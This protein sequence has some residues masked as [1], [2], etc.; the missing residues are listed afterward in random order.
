[1]ANPAAEAHARVLAAHPEAVVVERGRYH[2]KHRLA[3]GPDGKPRYVLDCWLPPIAGGAPDTVNKQVAASENDGGIWG[4]AFFATNGT[5]RYVG[6]DINS[7]PYEVF[8]RWE[9][10]TLSGTIDVS[11]IEVYCDQAATGTPLRKIRGVDEDNPPAPTSRAEFD[12]DPLTT[13]GV[14]WDGAWSVNAWNQ[15]GSLNAI[16][17]E[18]VDTYTISDDAVMVQIKD[19]RGGAANHFQRMRMYDYAGNLH[20][21]KLHIEY[22][23]GAAPQTLTPSAVTVPLVIPAPTLALTL[24]LSPTPVAMPLAVPA[25]TLLLTKTITP[26]PV[27]LP[28]AIPAP[29]LAHSLTL[30]P[31]P[32]SITLVIPAPTLVFGRILTPSPVAIALAIPAPTL[33]LTKTLAPDP[34]TIPL[35][36]PAPTLVLSPTLIPDPVTIPLTIPAPTLALSL[37]ITPDALAM[38]LAIPAPTV[39]LTKT[40]TPDPVAIALAIPAPTLIYPLILVPDPVSITLVIPAPTLVIPQILTPDPVTV[41]LVIP[42][43]SVTKVLVLTPDPVPILLVIPIPVIRTAPDIRVTGSVDTTLQIEGSVDTT[44]SVTGRDDTTISVKGSV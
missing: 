21:A 13:A 26:D 5:I 19:D 37:I 3:D 42:A 4:A 11:Y 10:V 15:S 34:V 22:T 30:T 27:S 8:A 38:P 25:P 24:T 12:A 14:D 20:G 33:L 36:I 39:V 9:G 44:I 18:L 40:L 43:P 2:I 23:G 17:Q 6:I 29:T 35:A 7:L 41:A 1:M 16:F 32:V 28:L 31:D